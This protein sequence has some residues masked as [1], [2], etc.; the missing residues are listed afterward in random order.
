MNMQE[1]QDA[2]LETAAYPGFGE[3]LGVTYCALGLNGEAGEVA[4]KIKKIQRDKMCVLSAADR[5]AI[6]KELGDCLWYVAVLAFELGLTLE[7][8]AVGNVEKL[9]SRKERG[10]ING[11]GDDR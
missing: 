3:W 9:R 7:S 6:K 4:D 2:A 11:S 10:K 1:Y 8:V 5:E